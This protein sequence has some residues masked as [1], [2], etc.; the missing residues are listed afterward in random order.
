MGICI[1]CPPGT[2][3]R[4]LIARRCNSHYWRR[5]QQVSSKRTRERGPHKNGVLGLY[6]DYH[7]ENNLWLC[8]NC[9]I[10]L[11][12]FNPKVASSCQAHILPKG[13]FK[14]VQGCLVNHMTLGGLHQGCFCHDQYDSSWKKAQSMPVFS[15][16]RE[17]FIQFKHLL[18]PQE[19]RKLP[20][21]FYELI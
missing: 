8:E 16:A 15:V 5:R 6:Y 20:A 12:P 10:Q 11:N 14:S 9:D 21:V 18:L 17:R 4:Y 7:N 19:I 3:P 2:P 1:D 13:I